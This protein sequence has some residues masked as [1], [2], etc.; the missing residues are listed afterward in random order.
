MA[1]AFVAG[2][3]EIDVA[4]SAHLHLSHFN[5]RDPAARGIDHSRS[6][7]HDR[8]GFAVNFVVLEQPGGGGLGPI[9]DGGDQLVA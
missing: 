2:V 6:G 1:F 9:E 7:A 8:Q 3:V 4:K 5:N